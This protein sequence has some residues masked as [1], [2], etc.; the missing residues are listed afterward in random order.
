MHK[1]LFILIFLVFAQFAFSQEG[2]VKTPI[3]SFQV[4]NN[5]SELTTNDF[6][7]A[8][9][10][11]DFNSYRLKHKKRILNFVDGS[12]VMLDSAIEAGISL[13]KERFPKNSVYPN[14]F[15][16]DKSSGIIIELYDASKKAS[17]KYN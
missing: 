11:G 1:N 16:L 7:K 4:E 15:K 3:N 10:E 6:L 9:S 2:N 5:S 17:S 13:N 14:S 12:K 8:I